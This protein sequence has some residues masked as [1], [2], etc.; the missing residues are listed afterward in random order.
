[1]IP[2]PRL[3][4][5]EEQEVDRLVE[6]GDGEGELSRLLLDLRAAAPTASENTT[7]RLDSATTLSM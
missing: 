6:T 3:T 2:M 5:T 4:P 1:M 7:P